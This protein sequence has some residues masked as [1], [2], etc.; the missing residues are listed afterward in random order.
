MYKLDDDG[1]PTDALRALDVSLGGLRGVLD[2]MGTA[3][4]VAEIAG[5]A[6]MMTAAEAPQGDHALEGGAQQRGDIM[7]ARDILV[8]PCV[9]F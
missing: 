9:T 7:A 6:D 4:S 1:H 8:I 3:A 5:L 2:L